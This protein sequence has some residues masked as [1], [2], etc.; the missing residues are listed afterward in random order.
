MFENKHFSFF[1]INWQ[2]QLT[3]HVGTAED[4]T[5]DSFFRHD[6]KIVLSEK[7]LLVNSY[8]N[9]PL[10]TK[11]KKKCVIFT[12]VSRTMKLWNRKKGFLPCPSTHYG[13]SSVQDSILPTLS[14][15]KSPNVEYITWYMN[16]WREKL[17]KFLAI[18]NLSARIMK[19]LNNFYSGTLHLFCHAK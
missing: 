9:F 16:K 11:Y 17:L 6:Q 14:L 12:Y 19:D 18:S 10:I 4:I 8:S 7:S 1:F 13:L 2:S 3:L 5:G 15:E